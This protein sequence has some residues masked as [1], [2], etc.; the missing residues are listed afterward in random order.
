MSKNLSI[1]MIGQKKS[2]TQRSF[3]LLFSASLLWTVFFLLAPP[4]SAQERVEGMVRDQIGAPLEK[5]SVV[6]IS[7]K[8]PSIGYALRTDKKGQFSLN[9]LQVGYYRVSARKSGYRTHSLEMR[10][11]A[12]GGAALEIVLEKIDNASS[13]VLQA[14]EEL[15]DRA[16]KLYGEKKFEQAANTYLEAIEKIPDEWSYQLN[17]GMAYLRMKK[18]EEAAGA[19]EKAVELNPESASARK[20]LGRALTKQDRYEEAMVQFLK[21]VEISPDDP[22]AQFELGIGYL[23]T[24]DQDA[25]LRAFLETLRL[26]PKFAEAYYHIGTI[27]IGQNR[28]PEARESL[29]RFLKLAPD[30]QFAPVARELLERLRND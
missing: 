14:G 8:N 25:A 21:A 23:N 22:E 13:R 28:V 19:F 20:E 27:F 26:D 15:F 11:S 7:H 6:I 5:V 29:A 2:R 12:A 1:M 9:E 18:D 17:L 4:I 10:V 16:N 24:M 30:N 3:S